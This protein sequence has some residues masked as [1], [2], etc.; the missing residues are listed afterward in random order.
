MVEPPYFGCVDDVAV[1]QE[2]LSTG[3]IAQLAA[4]GSPNAGPFSVDNEPDGMPDIWEMR[5]GLDPSVDDSG[6]DADGDGLTN[7]QEFLFRTNPTE[8]DC[9]GDGLPDGVE[10]ASGLNPGV[11]D[12]DDDPNGNGWSNAFELL[13]GLDPNAPGPTPELDVDIGGGVLNARG[14]PTTNVE[15][16]QNQLAFTFLFRTQQGTRWTGSPGS[17]G[18]QRRTPGMVPEPG[19]RDHRGRRRGGR[20]R[21]GHLSVVPAQRPQG[22]LLANRD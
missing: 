8:A 4:G 18:V 21:S 15:T 6:D 3:H 5:W 14:T 13:F 19:R 9:D 11:D 2:V 17:G 16:G 10:V 1:W 7:L 12:L 20:Y 22:S